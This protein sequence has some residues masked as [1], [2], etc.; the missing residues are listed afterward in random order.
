MALLVREIRV[1]LRAGSGALMGVLFFLAVVTVFPFAIGPDLNQLGRIG[2]AILWIG[3][4]LASLLGYAGGAALVAYFGR[5]GL[6][7]SGL[8]AGYDTIPGLTGIAYPRLIVESIVVPGVALIAASVL[9]ALLPASQ[10]ARLDP[11]QAIHHA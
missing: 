1:A 3:A 6:D 2:P 10:A 5:N 9:V 11:V 8:Y 7:L 4:L